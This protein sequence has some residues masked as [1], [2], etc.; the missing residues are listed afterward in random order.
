M[1]I[2]LYAGTFGRVNG[3]SYLVELA[4]EIKKR[5]PQIIVVACGK[6][7]ELEQ[8]TQLASDLGV[9]GNS[10]CIIDPVTKQK[11][12]SLVAASS[13]VTSTVIDIPELAANSANKVFDGW[14]ASKPVLINHLGWL[15]EIIKKNN[16]GISV[17]GK[18]VSLAA[19]EIVNLLGDHERYKSMCCRAGKIARKCFDRTNQARNV[20]SLLENVTAS[21]KNKIKTKISA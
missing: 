10:F 14:A 6:G 19:D 4:E 11:L 21:S 5:D 15:H 18:D 9:L 2:I 7:R 17:H 12:P 1:K 8:V 20:F 16:V 3:V 13:I